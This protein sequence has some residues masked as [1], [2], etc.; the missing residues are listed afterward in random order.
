MQQ[1]VKKMIE[2]GHLEVYKLIVRTH[3]EYINNKNKGKVKQRA[4]GQPARVGE[5][6]KVNKRSKMDIHLASIIQD[7]TTRLRQSEERLRV[8][9]QEQQRKIKNRG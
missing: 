4:V 9:K 5:H 7:I 8:H 6:Q 1:K 2:N 3:R